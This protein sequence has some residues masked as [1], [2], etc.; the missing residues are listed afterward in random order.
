M[1]YVCG[2]LFRGTRVLL[3]EKRSPQWQA[4]LL[5]GIGGKVENFETF[6]AAM[7]RE[8][9]EEVG[10]PID[11]TL[12][13]TEHEGS[14]ALVYFY[15]ARLRVTDDWEPPFKNDAGETLRWLDVG[16][17]PYTRVVGNLHWLVPLAMDPRGLMTVN[18]MS[19]LK[20]IRDNPT[21]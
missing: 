18:V 15:K 5:N 20:L 12:F 16:A 1:N 13:A 7:R 6:D 21:W 2:F 11:W 8:W 14:T 4:G 10:R 9:M 17:L 3:V 19:P